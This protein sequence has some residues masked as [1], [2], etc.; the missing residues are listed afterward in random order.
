MCKLIEA[1]PGKKFAR[2]LGS[3]LLG[4]LCFATAAQAAVGG[5]YPGLG[6]PASSSEIAA[7]NI[8]VRPDWQGLPKGSGSVAQGQVIWDRQCASCHGTFGES[9]QV[10]AP[11]VGGTTPDDSKRGRVAS[12]A[13]NK[14]PQRTTMM[15]LATLSTLWD[16]IRRAMPWNAPKSLSPDQVYAVTAYILNLAELVP[17]NFV[18]SQNNIAEVQQRLPN[19]DGMTRQ[20]GMWHIAGKPDV[21]NPAC[22]SQCPGSGLLTS[23]LPATAR[24]AH[25]N[26]ALQQRSFGAVRGIDTSVASA[27]GGSTAH[28]PAGSGTTARTG[29]V[30]GAAAS[31]PADA[32]A[33]GKSIAQLV[34]QNCSSCHHAKELLVGP[35]FVTVAEQNPKNPANI[36]KLVQKIK[37]GG[38]GEWGDIPM[39]PQTGLSDADTLRLV[40]WI[41]DGAK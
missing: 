20:H 34:E 15:K 24:N 3:N 28:A 8:D 1:G 39:P 2:V 14:E 25:G 22:M 13:N 30:A 31:A 26:L 38:V 33:S 16:Y 17:D 37:Q 21:I 18:L 32:A 7:W 41:L 12:L 6:R 35:A 36:A 27:S 29:A 40:E 10:F 23:I 19:R 9:N 5:S 4:W 11:I